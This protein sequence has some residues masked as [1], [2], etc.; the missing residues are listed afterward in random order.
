MTT[1]FPASGNVP[2]T[3]RPVWSNDVDESINEF[4]GF[5]G[6]YHADNLIV[7]DAA[8]ILASAS[9]HTK[10]EYVFDLLHLNAIGYEALNAE[11]VKI[12]ESLK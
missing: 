10:P 6:N 7:F 11:L 1:I 3:R 5:F 4:N 2:I 12:L 9:G 8:E